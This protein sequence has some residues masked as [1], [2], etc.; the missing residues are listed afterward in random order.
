MK[1]IGI[2]DG[3]INETVENFVMPFGDHKGELIKHV[4]TERL[5]YYLGWN[6][7]DGHTRSIITEELSKPRRERE[8]QQIEEAEEEGLIDYDD[9]IGL[10]SD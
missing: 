6:R 2:S 9:L 4:P 8:I 10:G 3:P 5:L 1:K 7:L